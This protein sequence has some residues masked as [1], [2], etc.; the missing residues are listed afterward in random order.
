MR[1]QHQNNKQKNEIE[2][3]E[4]RHTGFLRGNNTSGNAVI[5]SEETRVI[6]TPHFSPK[7]VMENASS[8]WLYYK[9][10]NDKL[11]SIGYGVNALMNAGTLRPDVRKKPG[12]PQFPS[13]EGWG[14]MFG[15]LPNASFDVESGASADT[16]TYN[17]RD[18]YGDSGGFPREGRPNV[19]LNELYVGNAWGAGGQLF[20]AV[21]NQYRDPGYADNKP[22]GRLPVPEASANTLVKK[23]VSFQ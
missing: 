16:M 20:E 2:L 12:L 10:K 15:D 4:A 5:S 1:K 3:R 19:V 9:K 14:E 11:A 22:D 18:Q 7:D 17:W 23:R 13:R 21:G 6:R 8:S